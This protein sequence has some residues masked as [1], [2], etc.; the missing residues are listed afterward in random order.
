M[1]SVFF[2]ILQESES[3][4]NIR[5]VAGNALCQIFEFHPKPD[6]IINE[7]TKIINSTDNAE[8]LNELYVLN[9]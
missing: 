8:K 7:L 3:S 6:S 2:R 1:Q 5:T 4:N 9:L